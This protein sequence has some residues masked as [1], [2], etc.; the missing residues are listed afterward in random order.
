MKKSHIVFVALGIIALQAVLLYAMGYSWLSSLG[1]LKLWHGTM[2]SPE[3]SQHLLDWYS[4]SHFIFGMGMYVVLSFIGKKYHWPIGT[5]FLFALVINAGWEVI[6]NTDFMI[7]RF[8]RT[9]ASDYYGDSIINSLS[10]TAVMA[11]GF[12]LASRLPLSFIIVIAIAI[13]LLS[14]WQIRQNLL[15]STIMITHPFQSLLEWQLKK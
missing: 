9:I 4:F 13:E 15:I 2:P 5:V 14:A 7:D 6:E 11:F 10:D 8:H 3:N 12:F 1:T